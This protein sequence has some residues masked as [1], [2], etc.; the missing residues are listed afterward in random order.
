MLF[1]SRNGAV[2]ELCVLIVR[3]TVPVLVRVKVWLALPP[4]M[5][6]PKLAA[7]GVRVAAGFPVAGGLVPARVATAG[8]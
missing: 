3:L 4:I 6:E 8:E 1:T 5:T 7:A 2:G